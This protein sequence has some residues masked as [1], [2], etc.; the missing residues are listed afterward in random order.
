MLRQ[1]ETWVTGGNL[2]NWRKPT[3]FG[4]VK[5]DN[6]LLACDHM[7]PESNPSHSGERQVHSHSYNLVISQ[8]IHNSLSHWYRT[9]KPTDC[10]VVWWFLDEYLACT[11][12]YKKW[13]SHS[14]KNICNWLEWY[15]LQWNTWIYLPDWRR[16]LHCF[17]LV[18]TRLNTLANIS[19][20]ILFY[21]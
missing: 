1:R 10:A 14:V 13:S 12:D 5:L 2:S 11:L 16:T 17:A 18:N 9:D 4:R 15:T 21:A 3:M 19:T 6:T 20:L 7:E 8:E